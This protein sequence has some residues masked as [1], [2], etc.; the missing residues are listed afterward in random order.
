MGKPLMN[1]ELLGFRNSYEFS[2][3]WTLKSAKAIEGA[4]GG[5]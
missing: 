4:K 5:C 2:K 3:I 1:D